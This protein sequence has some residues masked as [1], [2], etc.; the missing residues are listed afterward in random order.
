MLEKDSDL[1]KLL[2]VKYADGSFS[3]A[4]CLE[5]AAAAAADMAALKSGFTLPAFDHLASL[6]SKPARAMQQCISSGDA[7]QPLSMVMP[8]VDADNLTKIMLPHEMFAYVASKPE[9]WT[10]HMLPNP[11]GLPKFWEA[12]SGHPVMEGHPALDRADYRTRCLPLGLH[13]DEV[14]VV[15]VGKIWCRTA[16]V[17]SWFSLMVNAAGADLLDT[18]LYIWGVFEKYV[19]PCA[20]NATGTMKTFWSVM[21]WSFKAMWTGRWPESDWRGIRSPVTQKLTKIV[22]LV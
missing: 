21:L 9:K 3:A 18:M 8:Y 15:G 14:P 6:G 10:S 7:P 22:L 5:I 19:K 13:G 2:C 1:Y 12:F 11:D 16:L 4:T 20:P 17:F